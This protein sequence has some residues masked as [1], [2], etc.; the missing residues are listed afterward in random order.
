M[1][2]GAHAGDQELGI[3]L[4]ATTG[5]LTLCQGLEVH[6]QGHLLG[7][8]WA[9]PLLPC[10]HV[11]HHQPE[12]HQQ[13]PQGVGQ[14]ALRH[15]VAVG[16]TVGVERDAQ[17]LRDGWPVPTLAGT[18]ILILILQAHTLGKV[19]SPKS[20]QER[21]VGILLTLGRDAWW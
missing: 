8:R 10:Q 18:L 6:G 3:S 2:Q 4:A 16:I 5:A 20:E 14:D 11:A 15:K 7:Q 1:S 19:P 21:N 12:G 13:H 9:L 17:A